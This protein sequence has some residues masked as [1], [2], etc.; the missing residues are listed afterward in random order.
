MHKSERPTR[1][2]ASLSG[3][4][5]SGT[6]Q[7]VCVGAVEELRDPLPGFLQNRTWRLLV[8]ALGTEGRHGS[9]IGAETRPHGVGL[10]GGGWYGRGGGTT[11][12]PF[13]T[14]SLLPL[15]AQATLER[16]LTYSCPGAL[17]SICVHPHGL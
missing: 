3:A 9:A 13:E 16:H 12:G 7:H 17:V 8:P 4:Q 1:T 6:R 10:L 2:P 15:G 14:L 11:L 5:L